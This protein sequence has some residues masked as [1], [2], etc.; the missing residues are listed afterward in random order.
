MKRCL[1]S[2]GP[3]GSSPASAGEPGVVL[4][5][6]RARAGDVVGVLGPLV[7]RDVEDGVEPGPDPADFGRLLRRPLELVDLLESGLADLLRQVGA[8]D[9]G[10]VVVLLGPVAVAG[11]LLEL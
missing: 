11:Q 5:E 6:D 9:A 4:V 10:P 2:S 8:L 1:T 7:P 3:A